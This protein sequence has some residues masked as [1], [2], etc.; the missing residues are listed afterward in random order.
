[1]IIQVNAG[2]II[3]HDL[4][5]PDVTEAMRF[6]TELLGWEYQI[7]HSSDFVWHPGEADYPLIWANGEAHGGLVD[8]GQG[9]ISG[10]IAYVR[11]DDVDAVTLNAKELG[12]TVVRDPFDIPGVGRSAVIRDLQGAVICPTVPS[13]SFPPPSGTFARDDLNTE[14]MVIAQA[15]YRSLLGWQV[16]D[17]G[18]QT[19]LYGVKSD[20]SGKSDVIRIVKRSL[21]KTRAAIWLPYLATGDI[22]ATISHAKALGANV[23]L[24]R[25]G[26]AGADQLA[27][28]RD[29]QGAAFGLL[30][31][32]KSD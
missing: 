17:T 15:F 1:M 24:E 25:F 16:S 29:L 7:E 28:M 14:D 30:M 12:A 6:Y 21:T 22:E 26:E 27:I 10:W 11:V 8:S 20:H 2:Q 13:Y 9:S 23:V 18:E 4:L 32:R 3:W 5:T 19:S 31:S